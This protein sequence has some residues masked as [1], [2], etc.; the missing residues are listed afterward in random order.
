MKYTAVK[1]AFKSRHGVNPVAFDEDGKKVVVKG[2]KRIKIKRHGII[3]DGMRLS[4]CPF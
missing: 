2:K 4:L 1:K 3:V